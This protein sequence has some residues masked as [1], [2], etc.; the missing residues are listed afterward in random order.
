MRRNSNLPT[1]QH[2]SQKNTQSKGNMRVIE[3]KISL[4][5]TEITRNQKVILTLTNDFRLLKEELRAKEQQV[6]ELSEMYQKSIEEI[7]YLHGLNKE[8]KTSVHKL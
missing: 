8:L 7:K 1:L 3:D 4:H 6:E 2:S 5:E